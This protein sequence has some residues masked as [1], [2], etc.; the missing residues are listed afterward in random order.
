LYR[1][2]VF[3][4]VAANYFSFLSDYEQKLQDDKHNCSQWLTK[5]KPVLS[6]VMK[7]QTVAVH[8]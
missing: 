3:F 6:L 1:V 7:A 8:K 4:N 2:I 5:R